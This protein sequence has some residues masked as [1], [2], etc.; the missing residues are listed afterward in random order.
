MP[1]GNG[2][3]ERYTK[4]NAYIAKLSARPGF[5]NPPPPTRG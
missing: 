1:D 3:L 4:L 2:L 5:P